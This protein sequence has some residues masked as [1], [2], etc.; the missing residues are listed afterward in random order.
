MRFVA[1][2][3]GQLGLQRRLQNLLHQTGQQAA[4]AGQGNPWAS[5]R[6]VEGFYA[7][8]PV[9]VAAFS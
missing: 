6:F 7:A 1:K 9:S 2:V 3:V 5:P 8:W 4:V